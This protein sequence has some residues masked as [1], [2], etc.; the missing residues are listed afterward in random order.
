MITVFITVKDFDM[1]KR[2]KDVWSIEINCSLYQFAPAHATEKDIAPKKKYS[3]KFIGFDDQTT[4][5]AVQKA[6]IVQNSLHFNTYRITRSPRNYNINW[7]ERNKKLAKMPTVRAPSPDKKVTIMHNEVKQQIQISQKEHYNELLLHSKHKLKN[8]KCYASKSP[9]SSQYSTPP[10]CTTGSNASSLGKRKNTI[11]TVHSVHEDYKTTIDNPSISNSS[12]F[13]TEHNNGIVEGNSV[14]IG[15]EPLDQGWD[16]NT[17]VPIDDNTTL[18]ISLSDHR[19][20]DIFLQ[21]ARVIFNDN[22]ANNLDYSVN[23]INLII[24]FYNLNRLIIHP[25]KLD[26]LTIWYQEHNF[27][28]MG[29]A[30]TNTDYMDLQYWLKEYDNCSYELRDSSKHKDKPKGSEV[31][32][33]IY[34]KWRSNDPNLKIDTRIDHIW[35]PRHITP[36]LRF[37]HHQET[38]TL[39]DSDH[40]IVTIK[41]YALDFFPV[42]FK[43]TQPTTPHNNNFRDL[44]INTKE[45]TADN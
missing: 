32:L 19:D 8:A 36:S 41:L 38:H 4:P 17:L 31:G 25:Q 42:A 7:S 2:L 26:L 1:C 30:E 20:I 43:Y 33:L 15:L 10:K 21:R 40:D 35:I 11:T 12:N 22:F 5:A 45:I 34:D 14:I 23:F 28:F 3:G 13:S 44:S 29:I 37:A 16:L 18:N 9:Y 39:T 24:D 27:D 6:Y